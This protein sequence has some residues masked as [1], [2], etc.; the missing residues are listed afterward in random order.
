MRGT[1]LVSHDRYRTDEEK[2][3]TPDPL[4][5][6]FPLGH[7]LGEEIERE[8]LAYF[9]KQAEH[10]IG[11]DLEVDRCRFPA[12]RLNVKADLLSFVEAIQSSALNCADID[13]HVLAAAIWLDE[14]DLWW[15]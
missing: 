15:S 7:D 2:G 1:V 12:L 3:A 10:Y 6:I 9:L 4:M 8:T 5:A 14:A 11:S 13:K